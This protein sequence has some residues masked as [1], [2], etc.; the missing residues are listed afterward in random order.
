M[1]LSSILEKLKV[2]THLFFDYAIHSAVLNSCGN[3]ALVHSKKTHRHLMP[4]LM[5]FRNN[6]MLL[7]T[8]CFD[9]SYA[10]IHV[11]KLNVLRF[12]ERIWTFL[13]ILGVLLV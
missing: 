6:R 3:P 4:L 13:I 8:S 1:L 10:R 5:D 9:I 7:V 12:L 11:Y 2:R